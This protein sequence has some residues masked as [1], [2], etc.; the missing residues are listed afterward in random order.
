V[1]KTTTMQQCSTEQSSAIDSRDKLQN[2]S[3]SVSA[4]FRQSNYLL[5]NVKSSAFQ[6]F[7]ADTLKISNIFWIFK[8]YKGVQPHTAAEM[9]TFVVYKF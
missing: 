6:Q 9:D 1:R 4:V 7:V 8:F 2:V 3:S 5:L